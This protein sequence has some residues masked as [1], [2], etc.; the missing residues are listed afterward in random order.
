M[1][2][3]KLPQT[4]FKK[5]V[6]DGGYGWVVC[7]AVFMISMVTDGIVSCYGVIMP[8]IIRTFQCSSSAAAFIGALQSGITYFIAMLT[9]A[10]ANKVGC[11]YDVHGK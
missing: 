6:P 4:P 11:R 3:A 2:G 5:M 8:D 7:T 9:A 10:M 1:L